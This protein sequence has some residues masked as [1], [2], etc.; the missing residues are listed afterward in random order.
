MEVF[1]FDISDFEKLETLLEISTEISN[2]YDKL[3]ELEINNQKDSNE[4]T[5]LLNK[6]KK[7]ID[8]ETQ[9]Y[10]KRNFTHEDCI[11]YLKLFE[12]KINISAMDSRITNTLIHKDNRIIRRIMN[13]LLNI[14]DRS[15]GFHQKVLEVGMSSPISSMMEN[16]TKEELL[17]GIENGAKVQTAIDNDIHSMF[18]S[19]LEEAISYKSNTNYKNELIKAKYCILFAHKNMESMFIEMNFNIPD[20]IY[21]SSKIINQ[22]LNQTEI[23]YKLIKH[24]KLKS[25]AKHDINFLLNFN[26][27]EYDNRKFF[28]DSIITSCHIR[29][30]LSLME[31]NDVNDFNQEIHDV[32]DSPKYLSKHLNDR[33]SENIVISYFRYFKKDREKVRT[34]AAKA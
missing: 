28:F 12:S 20:N 17:K 2:V 8:K 16:I 4:Y 23:S 24:M 25:M 19:I 5:I 9:E 3:C 14:L 32:L 10:Q 33:I 27:A 13:N 21:T 7:L 31:E 15:K 26:D 6:L 29:A 30:I 11:K 34:L 18:L 22:L 1:K